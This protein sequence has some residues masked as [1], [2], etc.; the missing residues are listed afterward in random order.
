MPAT[1]FNWRE[2][3]QFKFPHNLFPVTVGNKYHPFLRRARGMSGVYAFW[4]MVTFERKG[5]MDI[6]PQ[7]VYIGE[8]HT[9]RLYETI[10]RHFRRWDGRA[11]QYAREDMLVAFIITG[12]D[13]AVTRQYAEI[14][15]HHPRDNEVECATSACSRRRAV[16]KRLPAPF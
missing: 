2:S 14:Q 8:S 5:V 12:S 9:R 3:E 10:T 13:E 11:A 16:R 6:L 7:I 15:I 1:Q 4:E